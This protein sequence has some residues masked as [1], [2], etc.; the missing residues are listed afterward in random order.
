MRNTFKLGFWMI[1]I[2]LATLQE[3]V[4]TQ[5]IAWANYRDTIGSV[6]GWAS[7][8]WFIN[9]Y[10]MI[11]PLVVLD[12]MAYF[13]A[14]SPTAWIYFAAHSAYC[15]LWL[16]KD[17]KWPHSSFSGLML[18]WQGLAGLWFSVL[19][20]FWVCPT[21][22]MAGHIEVPLWWAA[23]CGGMTIVGGAITYVADGYK[24]DQVAIARARG[25]THPL[26]TTGLW[27]HILHPNYTGEIVTYTSLSAFPL[28]WVFIATDWRWQIAAIVPL[29]IMVQVFWN[30]MFPN[31][32]RINQ[33]ML[34]TRGERWVQHTQKAWQVLPYIW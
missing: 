11:T 30:A 20:A 13:E 14:W 4:V 19:G 8:R 15:V 32:C 28:P 6:K 3:V 17:H 34:E 23:L 25:E 31:I 22:L 5:A 7:M 10:K 33:H 12:L 21:L 16:V 27:Q 2:Y 29:V 24:A 26:I 9:Y 18:N 1:V